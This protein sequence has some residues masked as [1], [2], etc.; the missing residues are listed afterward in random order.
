MAIEICPKVFVR[1]GVDGDFSSMVHLDKYKRTLLLFN[2]NR[3]QFES[4]CLTNGGGNSCVRYLRGVR[5]A[6]IPTGDVSGGYQNLTP[7][8]KALIDRSFVVVKAMIATGRF[9]KI[10]YSAGPDGRTLGDGIFKVGQ[11]VKTYITEQIW[12]LQRQEEP[13]LSYAARQILKMPDWQNKTWLDVSKALHTD[14]KCDHRKLF[15]EIFNLRMTAFVI[16]KELGL[17]RNIPVKGDVEYQAIEMLNQIKDEKKVL[18]VLQVLCSVPLR[19]FGCM[20]EKAWSA[21]SQCLDEEKRDE[22]AV[23]FF[24]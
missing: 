22:A 24:A 3:A 5:S 4:G 12:A 21:A 11:P 7:D 10:V 1:V 13:T 14:G 17:Q 6:E 8:V 9:D 20:I 15:L 18:V 2:G 19:Y 23:A 16:L